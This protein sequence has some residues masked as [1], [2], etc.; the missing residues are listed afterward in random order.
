M[1]KRY[2][3]YGLVDPDT[4]ELRYV[5][6]S[7]SGL[8]R[9]AQHTK[10]HYILRDG[11]V[12]KVNW[13]KKLLAGK[14]EPLVYVLEECIG[15]EELNLAEIDAISY[16]RFLGCNLTNI[17]PGGEGFTPEGARA[18]YYSRTPASRRKSKENMLR[19]A[20]ATNVRGRNNLKLRKPILVTNL[21]TGER[22]WYLSASHAS[23]DGLGSR[24]AISNCLRPKWRCKTNKGWKFEF[25]SQLASPANRETESAEW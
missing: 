13:I 18:A 17:Q 21:L 15:P 6:K 5:G 22:R 12:R 9:A 1:K 2:I 7:S 3:V 14:K 20:L 24:S 4:K 10:P 23:A 16:Y 11:N 8:R 19:G 25:I